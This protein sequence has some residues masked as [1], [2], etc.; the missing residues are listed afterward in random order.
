MFKKINKSIVRLFNVVVISCILLA[1][2]GFAAAIGMYSQNKS[3]MALASKASNSA[4]LAAIA[5]ADPLWNFDTPSIENIFKAMFLDRDVLAIRVQKI[6]S[7]A[8][9]QRPKPTDR[10]SDQVKQQT[11]DQIIKGQDVITTRAK[12]LREGQPIA[13]VSIFTSDAKVRASA[14]QTTILVAIFAL[15]LSLVMAYIIYYLG[16]RI[17]KKPIDYLRSSAEKL[18]QGHLDIEIDSTL[19]NEIGALARS[20]DHMRA[21]IK[22]K[23]QDMDVLNKTGER[24]ASIHDQTEAVE[25]A[26]KVMS[27][28]TRVERASIYI[29]DQETSTLTLHSYFPTF[30][31]ANT[32]PK[33]FK[34]N[35]GIAG[36]VAANGK[37]LFIQDT[38]QNPDYLMASGI[39]TPKSLLCVPMMDDKKIFG[40]MNFV[41]SP[42]LVSFMPED[43]AFALT[44][45]RMTVVTLKNIQ[46]LNL[47]AEQNRTLEERILD[48]TAELREKTNDVNNMLQNMRQGIFTV[49]AQGTIHTEHSAYLVDIFEPQNPP[50]GQ[51]A[52]TFLFGNSDVGSDT[53]NQVVATMNAVIG[54]DPVN[55]EF[56]AHLFVSEYTLNCAGRQKIIELDWNPVV[57][58]DRVDKIM[59]TARDVTELKALQKETEKQKIDLE[60]IGQ[61]L[62]TSKDKL[63]DFFNST[64]Q[65]IEENQSIIESTSFI[66]QGKLEELFRNM[67]TIKGNARTYGFTH[68]GDSVHSAETAYSHLRSETTDVWPKNELLSDLNLVKED[69]EKYQN[70][71]KDKLSNFASSSAFDHDHDHALSEIAKALSMVE[72]TTPPHQ[73]ISSLLHVRK[74]VD[75][76]TSETLTRMI[77]GVTSAVPSIAK[78][79][80][81]NTPSLEI[82]DGNLRIK[83]EIVPVLRNVFMH[84][85]RNALDHGLETNDERIIAEKSPAG[86]LYLSLNSNTDEGMIFKFNDDG[87]GLALAAIEA[88]GR[89]LGKIA[90]TDTPTDEQLAESIFLAGLS[91]ANLV[92]EVS[93]R[94]VGM[95]AVRTF[96]RKYR[97]DVKVVFDGPR[98]GDFRPFHIQV[99][100]P[101]QYAVKI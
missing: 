70:T 25:L 5:L 23:L 22:T 31:D 35:E 40:I 96:L 98:L 79:L 51:N 28:Q 21:A 8:N 37:T 58:I 78:Q 97:G 47:I 2:G 50:A 71:Y 41:G 85:F 55:F 93:G 67:H 64:T 63:L 53:I 54:E 74:S 15:F 92:T 91:T 19:D 42:N 36:Q 61:I 24:M 4:D 7:D 88:K 62:A 87:R 9:S 29:L 86:H 12:I 33:T 56:N 18:A 46:M 99:E 20:F 13:E 69:L 82:Q 95:D 44:I 16:A 49:T 68:M 14:S 80:G 17:I 65:F 32:F 101:A 39:E 26:L 30:S 38:T 89:S 34:L 52:V 72:D 57:D 1:L 83:K 45:A 6:A 66:D 75:S 81:K 48:R 27:D 94:G 77:S 90:P 59:I 84:L 11:F 100:L 10:V 73:L 76:L 3:L 43:E 60:I